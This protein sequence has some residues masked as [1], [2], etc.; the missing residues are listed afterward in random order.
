[1]GEVTINI[2]AEY[3]N[4][5]RGD[6]LN[7]LESVAD[8]VSIAARKYVDDR[9]NAEDGGQEALAGLREELSS[10][11]D[12]EAILDQI[13]WD[14]DPE[15]RELRVTGD[16]KALRHA[17]A[18]DFTDTAARINELCEQ[19]PTLNREAEK[20]RLGH[21]LEQDLTRLRF[22]RDRLLELATERS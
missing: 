10:L 8:A 5:F 19:A 17:I 18:V 4:P 12:V 3:A 20:F 13:G 16:A 22:F 21:W 9:A 11:H 14:P 15:V 6:V 1:M 7:W 2:P